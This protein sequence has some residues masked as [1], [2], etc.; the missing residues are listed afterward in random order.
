[1]IKKEL[2]NEIEEEVKEIHSDDF[3]FEVIESSSVPTDSDSNLT[4]AN[5]DSK[6]KKVKRIKTAILFIDIRKSTKISLKNDEVTMAKLYTSFTRSLIKVAEAH[7]G[8]I[9][10]I[11]GDR[12]MV[13]FDYGTCATKAVETAINMNEVVK[14]ILNKN[15]NESRISC[16]IG[17]DCGE[18]LVTKCGVI[19]K[20]NENSHYKNL[21]WSGTIANVASK[22][23]DQANK[24]LSKYETIQGA[25][26]GFIYPWNNGEWTW[27]FM[28]CKEIIDKLREGVTYSPQINYPDKYFNSLYHTTETK[29]DYFSFPPI[30]LTESVRHD[31]QIENAKHPALRNMIKISKKI[32]NVN[33]DIYGIK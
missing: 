12:L 27:T 10:N 30:L 19:K 33:K 21:T 14:T 16:G 31:L 3:E 20:G 5:F 18:V 11:I 26:V 9:R 17:I 23:T 6:T 29:S 4:F 25:N 24:S 22:L 28:T 7:N 13:A 2:L 1:M 8:Y 15:F 32:T